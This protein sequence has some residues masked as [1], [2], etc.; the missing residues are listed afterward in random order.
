MEITIVF[1]S[2]QNFSFSK[3]PRRGFDQCQRKTSY[4]PDIY[5]LRQDDSWYCVRFTTT[6]STKK[7]GFNGW[8]IIDICIECSRTIGKVSFSKT[9]RQ[10]W[11]FNK[12]AIWA[13][14]F[15]Y[16]AQLKTLIH[17]LSCCLKLIFP[18]LHFKVKMSSSFGIGGR[19]FF[20]KN[21]FICYAVIRSN[22]CTIYAYVWSDVT[23]ISGQI[24]R[25]TNL[26]DSHK[27]Q[28]IIQSIASSS[29]L[30]L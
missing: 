25:P 30:L 8:G 26:Q 7:Q 22:T 19:K 28:K 17:A 29:F 13:E 20:K 12:L 23:A 6:T 15:R 3:L 2:L 5:L 18:A 14:T 16:F 27:K 24:N 9:Q 1:V 10:D 4:I 11:H 21:S